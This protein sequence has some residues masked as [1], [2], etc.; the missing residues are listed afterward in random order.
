MFRDVFEVC[1]SQLSITVV[2][3]DRFGWACGITHVT[4][5]LWNAPHL[6]LYMEWSPSLVTSRF[7]IPP[8]H[9]M[10]S[11]LCSNV[12]TFWRSLKL[13]WLQ[14]RVR[15][16]S[17]Q[18][19]ID[20][21]DSF[22]LERW[23]IW[24]CNL[25]LRLRLPPGLAKLS[26]KYFGPFKIVDKLGSSDYKLLLPDTAAIH[27]VFHVSQLKQH[28]PNY[29]PMFSEIP[30]AAFSEDVVPERLNLKVFWIGGWCARDLQQ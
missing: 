13:T 21:S 27:P 26:F 19:L 12:K 5:P 14:H 28:T 8:I 2:Q 7:S 1:C 3:M 9:R 15:W 25:L 4:T 17:T 16:N 22:K 6:R 23:S 18:I 20:P 10:P 24:N 30:L 29:A 11:L